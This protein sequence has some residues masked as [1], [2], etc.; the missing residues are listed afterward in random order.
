MKHNRWLQWK[1][2]HGLAVKGRAAGVPL[3]PTGLFSRV[4]GKV[5]FIK[6]V[7]GIPDSPEPGSRVFKQTVGGGL[8]LAGKC[9]GE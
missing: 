4:V 7:P 9:N 3:K 2:N 5:L 1:L 8:G 6:A